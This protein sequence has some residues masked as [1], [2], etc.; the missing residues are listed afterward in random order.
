M[1][2]GEQSETNRK[3]ERAPM[4]ER[5]P[6]DA[7]IDTVS[8]WLPSAE[9]IPVPRYR[10]SVKGSALA[11]LLVL[12]SVPLVC[13]E[14]GTHAG[15]LDAALFEEDFL[16]EGLGENDTPPGTP[17]F[18]PGWVNDMTHTV[19]LQTAFDSAAE[20]PAPLPPLQDDQ[21]TIGTV[22]QTTEQ[23]AYNCHEH[24][25]VFVVYPPHFAMN[26][27]HLHSIETLHDGSAAVPSRHLIRLRTFLLGM[28]L[29]DTSPHH[30]DFAHIFV[31]ILPSLFTLHFGPS[32]VSGYRIN[33][34]TMVQLLYRL[35]RVGTCQTQGTAVPSVC[36]LYELA[37]YAFQLYL[38]TIDDQG[39]VLYDLMLPTLTY[40]QE[41]NVLVQFDNTV[42][43][44]ADLLPFQQNP[45]VYH[46][47][48]Q[49]SIVTFGGQHS[50][51]HQQHVF[52][53]IEHA[54]YTMHNYFV[55]LGFI[56]GFYYH[57]IHEVFDMGQVQ[58]MIHAVTSPPTFTL[59]PA[60]VLPPVT[61]PSADAFSQVA[62]A[63]N[64]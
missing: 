64:L 52:N 57:P 29:V 45:V 15:P 37:G 20:E 58:D 1:P 11:L 46:M 21:Y 43:L 55:E 63:V 28:Y 42:N 49:F 39:W 4:G 56:A 53:V 25:P 41:A 22:A 59:A 48:E 18:P 24:M 38:N 47:T 26:L 44:L 61:Q 7:M 14:T 60:S 34:L 9:V 30:A 27:N 51:T 10:S 35:F 8:L 62:N 23:V 40:M 31:R 54:P 2:G 36:S 19:N 33:A 12:L 5:H 17:P 6:T 13:C 16:Q 32:R 50:F 3:H